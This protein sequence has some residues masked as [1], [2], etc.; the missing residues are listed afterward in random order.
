MMEYRESVHSSVGDVL[1]PDFAIN[2]SIPLE[3]QLLFSVLVWHARSFPDD[4]VP[5]LLYALIS[6]VHSGCF[7]DLSAIP[8][9]THSLITTVLQDY[10]VHLESLQA[11]VDDDAVDEIGNIRLPLRATIRALQANPL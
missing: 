5:D 2:H 10:D 7:G 4:S 3:S 6:E 1:S 8:D 11:R 9:D